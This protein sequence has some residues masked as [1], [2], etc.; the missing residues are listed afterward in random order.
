MNQEKLNRYIL[1]GE[2]IIKRPTGF[3]S[4]PVQSEQELYDLETFFANDENLSAVVSFS[5]C[6]MLDK[7]NIYV[8]NKLCINFLFLSVEYVSWKICGQK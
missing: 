7:G 2:K 4:L 3:P 1:P 8:L 5:L 6:S